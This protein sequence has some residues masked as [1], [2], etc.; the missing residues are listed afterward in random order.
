MVK[1]NFRR[2]E[3]IFPK[4]PEALKIQLP[5]AAI[6]TGYA[7]EEYFHAIGVQE[8]LNNYSGGKK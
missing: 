6:M 5:A 2:L 7:H 8:A 1:F 3:S 4:Y